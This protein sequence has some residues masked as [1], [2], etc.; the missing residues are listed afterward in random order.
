MTSADTNQT[1]GNRTQLLEASCAA[2]K[3][4]EAVRAGAKVG[5]SK[6]C[7]Q[8]WRREVS[9]KRALLQLQRYLCCSSLSELP[10]FD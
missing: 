3:V 2:T 7:L 6:A 4:R 1:Q 10:E 5:S 8:L 9:S